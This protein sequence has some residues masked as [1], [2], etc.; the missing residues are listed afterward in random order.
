MDKCFG[1]GYLSSGG[2]G[3]SALV[4]KRNYLA[5]FPVCHLTEAFMDRATRV[6]FS[7]LR[8]VFEIS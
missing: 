5:V 3:A 2:G 6:A 1:H 8:A 4:S 7:A